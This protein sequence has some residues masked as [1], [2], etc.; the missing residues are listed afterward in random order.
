M[1]HGVDYPPFALPKSSGWFSH[2]LM[3][4]QDGHEAVEI[5]EDHIGAL[6]LVVITFLWNTIGRG[7]VGLEK[8]LNNF[9]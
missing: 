6:L 7:N 4:K 8:A 3:Y 2:V 5:R 9:K 1:S